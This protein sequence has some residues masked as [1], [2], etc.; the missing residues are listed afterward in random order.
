MKRG[1]LLACCLAIALIFS[2]SQVVSAATVEVSLSG[3]YDDQDFG[4]WYIRDGH[5]F[6]EENIPDEIICT[7]HDVNQT[8]TFASGL[9]ITTNLRNDGAIGDDTRSWIF[10]VPSDLEFTNFEFRS[11]LYD[12]VVGDLDYFTLVNHPGGVPPNTILRY[13]DGVMTG[14]LYYDVSVKAV[15]PFTIGSFDPAS[16]EIHASG[17]GVPIPSALLL[18]GSGF[19]GLVGLRRFGRK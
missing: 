4:R 6:L 3:P 16:L 17:S 2:L 5:T 12:L 11:D 8:Y 19:V 9:E 10:Q 18:L 14:D 15:D 1:G 13:Y 7:W